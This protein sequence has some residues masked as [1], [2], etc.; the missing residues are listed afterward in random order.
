MA[1][2]LATKFR[3]SSSLIILAK[4]KVQVDKQADFKALLFNRHEKASFMPNSAV[5][6]GGVCE[7]AD[8]NPVWR[9]HFEKELSLRITAIR[10]TFEEL[11]I[12]FCRDRKSLSTADNNG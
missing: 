11:G 12:I 8:E 4:D 5:F 10:E 1:K 6:P 2:Q 7:S 9:K 3:K